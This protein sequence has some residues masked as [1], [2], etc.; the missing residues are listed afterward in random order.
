MAT[1][2][3]VDAIIIPIIALPGT[4]DDDVAEDDSFVASMKALIA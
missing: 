3:T 1:R 2:Y 4:A